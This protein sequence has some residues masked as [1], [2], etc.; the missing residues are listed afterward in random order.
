MKPIDQ[1]TDDEWL[2]LVQHV[3]A[4]PDA[5][6]PLRMQALDLWHRRLGAPLDMVE[7]GAR[8]SPASK[9]WM[10]VLCFDSWAASPVAAGM[11]ALPTDLRQLLFSADGCD[12]DLRV[13]PR[14]VAGA[15]CAEFTL[16]GQVL[17][18]LSE[19]RV[20]ISGIDNADLAP[21]NTK[22]VTVQPPGEFHVE[23]VHA[24]SYRIVVCL[25]DT[26][27][28]LPPLEVGPRAAAAP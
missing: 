10:A 24:G 8:R 16:S 7:H 15:G 2:A 11:R 14:G 3:I 25:G 6:P 5:P 27:I 26:E 19:G 22:V 4:L 13:A 9:R 18:P 12:I 28:E 20:E 17:G 21:P 23:G 1:L